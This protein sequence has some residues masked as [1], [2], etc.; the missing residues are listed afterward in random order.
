MQCVMRLEIIIT[1]HKEKPLVLSAMKTNGLMQSL[2]LAS[3]GIT[4]VTI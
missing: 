2:W 4:I 1:E 3:G